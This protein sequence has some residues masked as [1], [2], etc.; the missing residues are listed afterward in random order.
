MAAEARLAEAGEEVSERETTAAIARRLVQ[1]DELAWNGNKPLGAEMGLLNFL[2]GL[3]PGGG[4]WTLERLF[5]ENG[6]SKPALF[7][8]GTILERALKEPDHA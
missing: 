1:A 5:D 8:L 2:N 4:K 7:D 3:S 6:R